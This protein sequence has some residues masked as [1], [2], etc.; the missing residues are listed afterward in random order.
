[1]TRRLV[2]NE[3][4]DHRVDARIS[5]PLDPL[6]RSRLTHLD[7]HKTITQVRLN[8]VTKTLDREIGKAAKTTLPSTNGSYQ[9]L[10]VDDRSNTFLMNCGAL[11]ISSKNA[12]IGLPPLTPS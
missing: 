7:E 3:S 12:M 11:A 2:V 5:S 4:D 8:G 10:L 6:S 1:M 9:R